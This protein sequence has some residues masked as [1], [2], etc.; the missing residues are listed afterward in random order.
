MKKGLDRLVKLQEAHP[1][2]EIT[3]HEVFFVD[4]MQLVSKK[5]VSMDMGVSERHITVWEKQ[6]FSAS[7]LSLSRL[8]LYDIKALRRW[9]RENI[10][11]KQSARTAKNKEVILEDDD[12]G[13]NPFAHTPLDKIPKIEAERRK[14]IEAVKKLILQNKILDG[15]NISIDATDRNMATQAATHISHLTNSE[16]ILP[17]LLENKS[18]SDIQ[19]ILNEHNQLQIEQLYRITNKELT[20]ENELFDV[21]QKIIEKMDDGVDIENL[22]EGID[23]IEKDSK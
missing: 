1:D 16:K 10:D 6:G 21:L 19:E 9:H 12:D 20:G 2:K 23:K 8:K 3:L 14:E 18:A 17:D 5:F 11:Q 15:E 4:N 7:D 13:E 22:I